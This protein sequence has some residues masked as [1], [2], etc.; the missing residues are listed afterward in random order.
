MAPRAE[1]AAAL[2]LEAGV[3]PLPESA[4][5][6]WREMKEVRRMVPVVVPHLE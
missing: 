4:V 6:I 5:E 1:A 2:V 3:A